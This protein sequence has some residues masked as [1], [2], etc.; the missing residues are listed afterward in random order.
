MDRE[1]LIEI[2]KIQL[3]DVGVIATQRHIDFG[4]EYYSN[5]GIVPSANMMIDLNT[6]TADT[7]EMNTDDETDN[8]DSP[9][10]LDIVSGDIDPY[11][12]SRETQQPQIVIAISMNHN[13]PAQLRL[14]RELASVVDDGP[15]SV[16][17]VKSVLTP[18]ELEKNTIIYFDPST[19]NQSSDNM[20]CANCYDNF[21]ESD[22]V[23]ILKC[24][25]KFHRLCIDDQLLN[26]SH[27]C[28]LCRTP[29]G[30]HI[31]VDY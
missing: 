1:S 14:L 11:G 26:K 6:E 3:E 4:L 28:P 9:N 15:S 20:E 18:E 8:S 13:I 23:R 21:V 16:S 29:S 19:Q 24:G 7:E 17:D 22:L 31:H 12:S 25:H 10:N 27:L 2:I 5:V 30:D